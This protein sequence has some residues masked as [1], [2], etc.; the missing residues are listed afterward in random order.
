MYHPGAGEKKNLKLLD[1]IFDTNIN[2]NNFEYENICLMTNRGNLTV[3]KIYS[4]I[5]LYYLQKSLGG[6]LKKKK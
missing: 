5:N 3:E 6:S 4:L 2:F 1:I